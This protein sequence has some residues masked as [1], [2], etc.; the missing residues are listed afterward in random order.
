LTEKLLVAGKQRIKSFELAPFSDG[1]FEV[2]KND[3]KIYS[4]LKTGEFPKE[5]TI[6]KEVMGS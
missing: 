2:F 4:K 5:E 6:V 1:R 3:K